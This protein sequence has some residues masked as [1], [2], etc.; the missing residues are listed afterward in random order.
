MHRNS[1]SSQRDR[2]STN[3][4]I[5]GSDISE[6]VFVSLCKTSTVDCHRRC[7][8]NK[9]KTR[10]T[11]PQARLGHSHRLRAARFSRR[12]KDGGSNVQFVD[13]PLERA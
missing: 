9:P 5:L 8:I 10:I 6:D 11:R 3:V 13:L 7:C 4:M 12:I 2:F 1:V